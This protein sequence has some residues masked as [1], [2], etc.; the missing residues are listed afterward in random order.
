MNLSLCPKAVRMPAQNISADNA[1]SPQLGSRLRK[2]RRQM[3]LT[4]QEMC[5]RAGLSVGYLSQLERDKAV[6][7]LATL[8]QIARAMDVSVDFFVSTHKPTDA[9]SRA[10]GRPRFSLAGSSV[11]YE[12]I[13]ADYPGSE[14]SSYILHVPP[15]YASETVSHDGEEI[16]I[17]LEGC[18]DVTLGGETF[19]MRQGDSMHYDGKTTH[20]WANPTDV[21]ARVLWTGM[22]NILNPGH[23]RHMPSV[24]AANNDP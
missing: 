2:R 12:A 16:I 10:Q 15:N 20:S 9:F 5:D 19:V 24:I 6:P 7:T 13:S 21:P 22:L 18:I 3:G 17:M 8:A 14:L 23:V 11:V 1:A 4:L